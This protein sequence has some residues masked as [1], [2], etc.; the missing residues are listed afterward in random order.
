MTPPN[1]THA[2]WAAIHA[3]ASHL[4]IHGRTRHQ[5]STQAVSLPSIK[6]AVD[7]AKG[8]VPCVGNGDIWDLDD[9]VTMREETGVRG[10]MAARGLLAKYVNC[11]SLAVSSTNIAVPLTAR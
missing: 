1:T 3:G 2:F 5:A 6:F 7:A 4:T 8:E 10:V 11:G 9:V